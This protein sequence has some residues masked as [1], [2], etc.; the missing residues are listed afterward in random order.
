MQLKPAGISDMSDIAIV[1]RI[2]EVANY[3]SI[4]LLKLKA[5]Y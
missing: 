5:L 1:N 3:K 4:L 2:L